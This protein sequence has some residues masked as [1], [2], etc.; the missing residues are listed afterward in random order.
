VP[1]PH[2]RALARLVRTADPS[3][4]AFLTTLLRE[5]LP[6]D[7]R[8]YLEAWSEHRPWPD[9]RIG[10]LTLHAEQPRAASRVPTGWKHGDYGCD[11]MEVS[12]SLPGLILGTTGAVHPP[13]AIF[14][15]AW[16]EGWRVVTTLPQLEVRSSVIAPSF[17]ALLASEHA[18]AVAQHLTSPLAPFL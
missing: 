4:S 1:F 13:N 2:V 17:E 9:T 14:V 16:A 11:D 6:D 10:S 3:R 5:P 18:R 12:G 15:A 7:L 8:H